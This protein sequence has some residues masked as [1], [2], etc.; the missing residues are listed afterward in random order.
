MTIH[1]YDTPVHLDTPFILHSLGLTASTTPTDDRIFSEVS[2]DS[3]RIIKNSLFVALKG[4]KMDGHDFIQSVIETGASGVIC[5]KGTTE[6]FKE[7]KSSVHFFEVDDPL[8]AYRL[9]AH[10]WRRLFNIP[11]L[12]IAGSAGKTTTK[13][14]LF[15]I[16]QGKW[17]NVLKTQASQNGFIGI[18]MTLLGLRPEHQVAVI[19]IG[20]DECGAM[21][22]HM[23][24]V[25]PTAALLTAIGPEHL[26]KLKDVPTV[27]HEE[28]IALRAVAQDQGSIIVN[29]DDAWIEPLARLDSKTKLGYSLKLRHHDFLNVLYGQSQ[30]HKD[31]GDEVFCITLNDQQVLQVRPPLPGQHNL[32]NL[33][34]AIAMAYSL[35]LS[36]S[37]IERG[38]KTFKGAEGR[39]D[40][41]VLA[42]STTV[43][44]DYYNAQPA[45][46]KAGI[47]MLCDF[48]F[49]ART[50]GA[51][52]LRKRWAVLGDMLE[53]GDAEEVFH[54]EIAD[55]LIEE[56]I[57]NV[58]LY[59]PRMIFLFDELK[60]RGYQ[61]YHA[62]F[63]THTEL[64]QAL[65]SRF[66]PG[67]TLLIKG[68]RGMRMEEVWKMVENFTT[69]HWGERKE[70]S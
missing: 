43:L 29:L 18:P 39:S 60:T 8:K 51:N 25:K 13:E 69:S 38:L 64:T 47:Q 4:E 31:Q 3:R 48:H 33:L 14:L 44:C 68:S 57:E 11:I 42:G 67:D 46:M 34:G 59:G 50:Q 55:Q 22:Q 56:G 62:H 15:S 70:N 27:A 65:T 58:L 40:V 41:R 36:F 6:R 21:S 28:S 19:E 16:L 1:P 35:G 53:L 37:E 24:L 20:I 5:K 23:E 26:E 61:G 45:S 63:K 66:Q 32:S 30:E 7:F 17:S 52:P 54:R 49:K 2:T 10:H 9:L 12:A